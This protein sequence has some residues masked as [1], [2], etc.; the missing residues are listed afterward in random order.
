M[1]NAKE[2]LDVEDFQMRKIDVPAWNTQV[3]IR[4]MSGV[5]RDEIEQMMVDEKRA[6]LKSLV[7]IYSICDEDGNRFY[8]RSELKDMNRKSGKALD[9]VFV[10]A[11]DLNQMSEDDIEMLAQRIKKAHSGDSPTGGPEVSE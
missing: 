7:A 3:W 5:Q 1:K 9:R 8:T 11:I 6:N 4:T 2:I 10:E